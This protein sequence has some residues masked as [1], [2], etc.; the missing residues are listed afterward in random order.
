MIPAEIASLEDVQRVLEARAQL[1][2][3]RAVDQSAQTQ[4]IEL[5]T[6]HLGGEGWGI[7]IHFVQEIQPLNAHHWTRVPCAPAFIIGAIN[8]RGH[9]YSIMDLAVFLGRPARSMTDGPHILLIKG[10]KTKDGAK[11]ELTLL[12]DDLPQICNLPANDLRPAPAT[13]SA[14]MQEFLRGVSTEM[15]M[16]LDIERLLSDPV[17]IVDDDG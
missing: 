9:I 6:F 16:V 17:L 1:L 7:P 4:V 8:L 11:M 15:V 12:A 2:A 10:G 3:R 5:A 14:R 13:V